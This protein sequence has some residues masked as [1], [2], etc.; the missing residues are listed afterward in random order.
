MEKRNY[1]MTTPIKKAERDLNNLEEQR[2]ALFSRA[3]LLSKQ[4]DHIAFAALTAGDKAAKAKL[5]DIN[6][7][8]IGL[9]ANIASVEA[10]LTVARANLATAETA[11]A[12]AAGQE[13]AK[14]IA[15][16]NAKLKAQLVDADEAFSD[17][18]AS[19]L[20]A[21]TLL[22]DMHALGVTSP[23]DQ[24]LRINSVAA[25]KTTLQLLPQPWVN[26]FEFMRLAP[27][28]KKTFKPLA[29]AWHDQIANQIAARLP[30]KDAA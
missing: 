2:E 11:E 21:R 10:A 7:E 9:A 3:K 6:A 29:T 23:T 22:Q 25:I 16:L 12:T 13:R 26:D 14:L 19:V 30:K 8:D 24:Q 20:N 5:S 17:A 1:T 4:R 18:I 15:E 28:Q 27:S